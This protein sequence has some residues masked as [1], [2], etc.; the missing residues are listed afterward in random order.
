MKKASRFKRQKAPQNIIL[1][2]RDKEILNRV[3]EQRYM[4]RRQIQKLFFKSTTRVNTRLRQLFD[5][6]FLDRH[7]LYPLIYHGSS[8][9]IY[10]LGKEG[11][12]IVAEELGLD[13]TQVKQ[14]RRETKRLKPFFI[15]HIL[16]VN[17]FRI[18]FEIEAKDKE[19]V[20][21]KRWIPEKELLDEYETR[22]GG[23]KVKRRFKPDGYGRYLYQDKLYS[24]FLEMDRSTETNKSFQNKI[25]R[26]L[27]Y[28]RS[29]RY[30]ELFGVRFF[31]LLV[32][33]TTKRRLANLKKATEEI[34]N[35]LVWFTTMEKIQQQGFWGTIWRK[36]ED[37]GLYSLLDGED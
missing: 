18:A 11:V 17:D 25:R 27:D 16:A 23:K 30:S 34:T 8:Q 33:T 28:K 29:G 19:G 24:F 32:V 9:S 31:K 10:S 2:T 12:E 4:T 14:S 3:Y 26:Y 7:F 21:F 5:H 36:A 20:E 37:D 35:E 1:Q 13:I 15:H 22:I 6:E